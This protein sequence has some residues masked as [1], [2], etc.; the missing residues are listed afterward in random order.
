VKTQIGN[1]DGA[2]AGGSM[3]SKFQIDHFCYFFGEGSSYDKDAG[4]AKYETEH[5]KP[6]RQTLMSELR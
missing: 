1:I 6:Q 5:R 3:C 2:L 4:L